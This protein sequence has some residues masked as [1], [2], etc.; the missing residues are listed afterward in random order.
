MAAQAVQARVARLSHSSTKT[1]DMARSNNAFIKKQRE[2]QRKRD[3]A[4]KVER[5][6][7]RKK[8][9]P[10][11]SLE[12]MMAYVDEFGNLTSKPPEKN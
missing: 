8:N 1:A 10:G 12:N 9:S 11:G 4:E 2:L 7:E 6:N 3:Q 5:K